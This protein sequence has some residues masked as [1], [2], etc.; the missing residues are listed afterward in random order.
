MY[1]STLCVLTGV[2][3]PR[4]FQVGIIYKNLSGIVEMKPGQNTCLWENKVRD[5]ASI[6]SC[7]TKQW[8]NREEMASN[9]LLIYHPSSKWKRG[10][11]FSMHQ[12]RP[13]AEQPKSCL[14]GHGNI[15][16]GFQRRIGQGAAV[17]VTTS[18]AVCTDAN[19]L[20]CR[21][22]LSGKK[23]HALYAQH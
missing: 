1:D 7:L 21:T 8:K 11:L 19:K 20:C 6:S 5:P 3:I 13:P 22:L 10:L 2:F 23:S 4:E 14:G 18:A 15:K 9:P 12:A 17:L 16:P